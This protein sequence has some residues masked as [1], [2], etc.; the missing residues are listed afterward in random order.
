MAQVVSGEYETRLDL[1]NKQVPPANRQSVVIQKQQLSS[2]HRRARGGGGGRESD[3]D[4]RWA[5]NNDKL[6]S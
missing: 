1:L 5:R 6:Q 4:R 2:A 3:L